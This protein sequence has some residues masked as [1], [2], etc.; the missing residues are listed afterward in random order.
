M[1]PER[2]TVPDSHDRSC[3]G[4]CTGTPTD[5]RAARR[6]IRP[7]GG[8]TTVCRSC[9]AAIDPRD[10]Y[11]PRCGTKRRSYR[12]SARR[13]STQRAVEGVAK[14]VQDVL[15]G[16]LGWAF[17]FTALG[18]VGAAAS[19]ALQGSV[20]GS[21]L[22]LLVATFLAGFGVVLNPRFG[23]Q[24]ANRHAVTTFGRERTVDHRVIR[25]GERCLEDCVACGQGFDVGLVRRRREETVVAG[26]PVYT[27]DVGYNH[28]CTDCAESHVFGTGAV[29][30]DAIEAAAFSERLDVDDVGGTVDTRDDGSE[31][32]AGD[33]DRND[34][35]GVE[36]E[37]A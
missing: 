3:T 31:S 1:V 19:A 15:Y 18:G 35:A 8:S 12:G 33:G 9:G 37:R 4:R 28:Y 13:S 27:H 22:L 14:T 20:A 36:S 2:R 30:R 29:D 24:L 7:D 32:D 21:L 17:V 11:C 10:R 23:R 5:R 6:R 16:A 26:L 25:P 34:Q